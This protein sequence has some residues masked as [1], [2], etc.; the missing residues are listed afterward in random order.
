MNSKIILIL[1]FFF[2]TSNSYTLRNL[3]ENPFEWL[4]INV[5][6][7]EGGEADDRYGHSSAISD[8]FFIV[9]ACYSKVGSKIEQGKVYVFQKEEGIWDFQTTIIAPDGNEGDRFGK[10]VAISE[11]YI[12]IG[13][14]HANESGNVQ[15]GKVYIYNRSGDSW[16][17]Q[18][19]I[20]ASDATDN[21]NFGSS[22]SISG[23]TIVVGA[24][25]SNIGLLPSVGKSYIFGFDGST[26]IERKILVASDGTANANF[27]SSVSISGNYTIIGADGAASE[28]NPYQGKS[29]LFVY[30]GEDWIQEQ[31]LVA[32]DGSADCHF[33]TSLSM[34]SDYIVIGAPGV[35]VGDKPNQGQAYVFE[36]IADEWVETK[37]LKAS[38]GGQQSFFGGSVSVSHN[39][40]AVG[41]YGSDVEMHGEAGK[42]YVFKFNQTAWI[43]DSIL[44]ASDAFDNDNF[45]S[46][47]A[48]SGNFLV[49]G[50]DHANEGTN[51]NVGK[52]Y[53]F[54]GPPIPSP[55]E[56]IDCESLFSCFQCNWKSLSNKDDMEYFM[57]YQIEGE[58]KLVPSPSL[59]NGVYSYL[60]NSY[61]NS[62]ITGNEDY[63]IQFKACNTSTNIC[64]NESTIWNLKTRINGVKHLQVGTLSSHSVSAQWGIPDVEIISNIPNLHHYQIDYSAPGIATKT[65]SVINSQNFSV[66]SN[67]N[68]GTTYTFTVYACRSYYCYGSDIGEKVS[69][70]STTYVGPVGNLTCSI[71]GVNIN[72]TWRRPYDQIA[73]Y[74]YIFSYQCLSQ[75]DTATYQFSATQNAFVADFSNS[76]YQVTAYACDSG[77]HCGAETSIQ[78][79]TKLRPV[80]NFQCSV[81]N[82]YQIV[83]TWDPPND[84]N[85]PDSYIFSFESRSD[86]DEGDLSTL[87]LYKEIDAKFEYQDYRIQVAACSN[88]D[89]CGAVSSIQIK[90]ALN[91]VRNLN[92]STNEVNINC[93]WDHSQDTIEIG[94]YNVS[95]E[96]LS[97]S[98][99]GFFTTD[100]LFLQFQVDLS[101]TNYQI[102]VSACTNSQK[103]SEPSI[104]ETKTQFS[105]ITNLGCIATGVNVS[106]SW[107]APIY[108]PS[109]DHYLLVYND[110]SQNDSGVFT[111]NSLA[112]NFKVA[113]SNKN[114]EVI[115]SVCDSFNECSQKSFFSILTQ[116]T[117]VLNLN[118]SVSG[119][120]INCSWEPP[121]NPI[122]PHHYQISYQSHR[123]SDSDEFNTYDCHKTFSVEMSDNYSILI[124]ACNQQS[125]CG[126]KEGFFLE[127]QEIP[128]TSS[129]PSLIFQSLSFIFFLIWLFF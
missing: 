116:F 5:T 120:E 102:N 42:A 117:K 21:S 129:A 85:I 12:V 59:T 93:Y 10:S 124:S 74:Y 84:E 111:T 100:D 32:S 106:C 52:L 27:G 88:I 76:N 29:Y 82:I 4:Q 121:E 101:N 56:I 110:D 60:F 1:F 68:S 44:I 9:G 72:C 39:F 80:L 126:Q 16:V 25:H 91:K 127:T 37:I 19:S 99:L 14:Y 30:N 63:S 50:S 47:I 41:A 58:W 23:Q 113:F 79:K 13:A 123:K 26:W 8:S 107:N 105:P 36:K 92:C 128:I 18:K 96:S 15:S 38:D 90:T 33:G 87:A 64:G 94:Y 69:S 73:P 55:V 57:K 70:S 67:L 104:V 78:I 11:D 3:G 31:I 125:E 97:E 49:V 89:G 122:S 46:S 77:F 6:S 53:I 114:Y 81:M 40:I 86:F 61:F 28:D 17:F 118:C 65:M 51:L 34:S 98:D 103:C 71:W 75:L 83:C 48:I 45:G 24:S 35:R 108:T 54:E 7:P 112:H 22:V 43:E 20:I 115:V 66:I 2:I 119:K 109:P 62:D 95:Y